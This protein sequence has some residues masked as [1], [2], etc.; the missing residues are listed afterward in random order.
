MN[1]NPVLQSHLL[2]FRGCMDLTSSA[3]PGASPRPAGARAPAECPGDWPQCCLQEALAAN[4][5][6]AG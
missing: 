2:P 5:S 1:K 3:N 4:S 6:R